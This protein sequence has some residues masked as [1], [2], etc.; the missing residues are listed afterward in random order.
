MVLVPATAWLVINQDWQYVVPFINTT[1]KPWRL[2]IIVCSLP[3][4][5]SFLILLFLPET[6]K[7]VFSQGNKQRAYEILQKMNRWNNGSNS[8]LEKFEILEEPE[9]IAY[10]QRVLECEESRF[11]LLK[12]IYIQTAPLFQRQHRFTTL[13]LCVLQFG[14]SCTSTGLLIFVV[15]ILNKMANNLENFIDPRIAM[16][17]VI[18]MKPTNLTA[19]VTEVS[20]IYVNYLFMPDFTNS[21]R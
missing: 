6:P 12:S 7:F 13:L 15:D 11:P 18:N 2:F 5:I 10:R 21:I 14:V 17:D 8:E 1:Y 20:R 9:S 19:G 4:F 3:G 16:C